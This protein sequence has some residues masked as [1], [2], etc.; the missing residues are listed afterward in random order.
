M[1]GVDEA[2]L[3]LAVET[4][5]TKIVARLV[6]GGVDATERW[7]T[8]TPQQ[9]EADILAFFARHRPSSEQVFALGVA[10]F[11]PIVLD[12]PERG[13]MLATPK[14]H[15]TGSNL[16]SGLATRLGCLFA[17]E[18]D[19]NAAA[20]AEHQACPDIASL[21]YVTIG[22]GIG[23]GLSLA[24]TTLRGALHPEVGHLTLDRIDGDR[25]ASL[26]PFHRNCAEGLTSGLAITRRLAGAP[27]SETP[28]MQDLAA[29]YIGQLLAALVLAWT[30]HRIVLG[31]GLGTATDMLG[32]VREKLRCALGDYGVGDA[33]RSSDFL[34]AP[35][36]ADPGLAGA[37]LIAERIARNPQP[38]GQA[39]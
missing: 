27:L 4:G 22:T 2:P 10:S 20:L 16:A 37:L 8:S 3:V 32:R 35:T 28:E 11:G 31:G 1:T 6:G 38:G 25:F 30:P 18:T 29:A 36:L 5:G 33:A 26:C 17:I 24:G 23:G 13:T 14:P 15:W 39:E 19:V 9:A 7:P 34:R 21:A 12:G